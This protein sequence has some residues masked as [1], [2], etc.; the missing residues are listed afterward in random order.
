MF[1]GIIEVVG[2]VSEIGLDGGNTHFA[3]QSGVSSEL[4]I[5][6]SVSH[7]GVCLTVTRVDGNIHWVTAVNETLNK[8]N[9]RA[10]QKDS[11][12]NLER[13]MPANGRFDGHIVQGHVD[14]TGE[15]VSITEDNG[16]WIF[17]FQYSPDTGNVTVEKGS[18]SVN[19]V[20]LTCFN[21]SDNGFSVA[22]IPYTFEHTN[23]KNLRVGDKVN[24]EFDIIGKYV[25]RLLKK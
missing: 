19:G 10:L 7:N 4:K 21:S 22:I 18:I 23:F 14:Q 2:K 11:L 12:V 17:S 6:Q 8:S 24:L 16:S 25:Q 9:L 20:S 13:C 15:C 5:D 1:T 3:I